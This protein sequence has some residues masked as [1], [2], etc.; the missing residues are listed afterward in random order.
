MTKARTTAPQ[1]LEV[2]FEDQALHTARPRDPKTTHPEALQQSEGHEDDL[3]TTIPLSVAGEAVQ[4]L[5]RLLCYMLWGTVLVAFNSTNSTCSVVKG[6][7]RVDLIVVRRVATAW[8]RF[9][10][11]ALRVL[12]FAGA[13][14]LLNVLYWIREVAALWDE[15]KVVVAGAYETWGIQPDRLAVAYDKGL[16]ALKMWDLDRS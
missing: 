14:I 4:T 10:L 13:V 6:I 5:I 7:F 16:A 8:L 12:R 9:A 3:D 1:R 2:R 11:H 15:T